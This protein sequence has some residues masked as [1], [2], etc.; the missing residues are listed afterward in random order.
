[1]AYLVISLVFALV[2]SMF[3]IQNAYLVSLTFFGWEVTA[4]FALVVISATIAGA[5]V[6]GLLALFRQVGSGLRLRDERSRS[7]R[8]VQELEQAKLT[9][10]EMRREI[11]RLTEQNR[12]LSAR[13]QELT[14]EG[15]ARRVAG[16]SPAAVSAPPAEPADVASAS[17]AQPATAAGAQARTAPKPP[18]K[19]GAA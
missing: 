5:L 4:S 2:I 17:V 14:A 19:G 1:M 10:T 11:D 16:G 3:A 13:V 6:V 15:E 7:Q 18:A 12:K 8:T 9:T